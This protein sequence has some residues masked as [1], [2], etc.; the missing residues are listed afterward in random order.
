MKL[1]LDLFY[2]Y[3][4]SV[5]ED[6]YH[7]T[8]FGISWIPELKRKATELNIQLKL[9]NEYL[10]EGSFSTEDLI[11]SEGYTA[12]TKLL[13]KTGATPFLIYSSE[14]PNV[15]WKFYFFIRHFTKKYTHSLLYS[16]CASYVS[17]NTRFKPLLWPNN[18]KLAQEVTGKKRLVTTHSIVMIAG[19]KKQAVTNEMGWLSTSLKKIVL[20]TLTNL[21]GPLH[22]TDLYA[23][24][25][26]AIV[27]FSKRS[28]FKL[29]G[30]NWQ[31]QKNLTA[32]E[33]N[34]IALLNPQKI[35][36]KYEMLRCFQF[37]LCFENCEYPGYITEKIFDCFFSGCIPVYMGAPDI[38]NYIP[39]DLFIDMRQ[40]DCFEELENYL[41]K[42]TESEINGYHTRIINYLNSSQFKQFTDQALASELLKYICPLSRP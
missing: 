7:K 15:D 26:K 11:L 24:R 1:V 29:Y 20:G 14:S 18:F 33:R 6:A 40:F 22:L 5:F 8:N 19:N 13:I 23:F 21:K 36:D 35:D 4:R 41:N 32:E 27:F 16:G 12:T 30:T 34:A 9:A 2:K 42:L 28:Y 37:A 38:G 31:N 10:E 3:D 17:K 25:M 39:K